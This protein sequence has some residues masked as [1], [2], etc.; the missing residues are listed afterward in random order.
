MNKRYIVKA[1]LFTGVAQKAQALVQTV[2]Q[3]E[4]QLRAENFQNQPRKARAGAHVDERPAAQVSGVQQG[5]AVEKV[6]ARRVRLAGD[7][8][9]IHDTVICLKIVV[10]DAKA[11]QR[12]LVGAELPHCEPFTKDLFQ[13]LFRHCRFLC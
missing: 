7:G 6:Q 5:G 8:G 12:I 10:V 11:P 4:L 9:E 13:Y 3:G 2:Q 1:Q